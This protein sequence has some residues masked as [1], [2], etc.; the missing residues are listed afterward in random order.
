MSPPRV[1]DQNVNAAQ[2][3]PNLPGQPCHHCRIGQVP[4]DSQYLRALFG[5]DGVGHGL[6][7]I[8]FAKGPCGGGR[9]AVDHHLR[10]QPGQVGCDHPANPSRRTRHPRYFAL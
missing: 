2:A 5:G 10:A 4:V 1:V 9:S 8:S 3:C 7:G 6:K